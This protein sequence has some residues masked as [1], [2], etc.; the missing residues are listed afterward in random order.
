M[1]PVLKAVFLTTL[2]TLT[3]PS[4]GS[5][6]A[7][8]VLIK[9]N[10][11]ASI[12]L[13][14]IISGDTGQAIT[15]PPSS[16]T[17]TLKAPGYRTKKIKVT[18]KKGQTTIVLAKLEPAKR[19]VI[20]GEVKRQKTPHMKLAKKRAH[21]KEKRRRQAK[22][23]TRKRS[24]EDREGLFADKEPVYSHRPIRTLNSRT[25][26]TPLTSKP[27]TPRSKALAAAPAKRVAKSNKI[28]KPI[29]K[30]HT[31]SA[32][33]K[34]TAKK[35]KYR[36]E[37]GLFEDKEPVYA[38]RSLAARDKQTNH[39]DVTREFQ[40][41]AE[42]RSQHAPSPFY[43]TT[44]DGYA[45]PPPGYF[46][47]RSSRTTQ[48]QE[49]RLSNSHRSKIHRPNGQQPYPSHPTPY[50]HLGFHYGMAY[51]QP[52]SYYQYHR[53]RPFR[54]GVAPLPPPPRYSR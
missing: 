27:R 35:F 28:R 5:A 11:K 10:V 36:D 20:R 29:K 34:K 43:Q 47:Q 37:D 33:K 2:L 32:L 21:I 53:E 45:P 17:L 16:T 31:A 48:P 13:D 6:R 9:S 41:Q 7:T 40:G 39:Q 49:H 14:G 18:P 50:P 26:K 24:F 30:R 23:L 3:C 52:A 22:A 19:K 51:G 54:Y 8:L 46:G 15:V 4:Y 1:L 44:P 12:L 25:H 42:L 38:E